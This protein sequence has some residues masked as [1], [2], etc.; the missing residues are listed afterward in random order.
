MKALPKEDGM[1]KYH[2]ELCSLLK[3]FISNAIGGL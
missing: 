1:L 3:D 2:L